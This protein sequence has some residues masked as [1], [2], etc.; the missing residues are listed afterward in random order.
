[1]AFCFHFQGQGF[2]EAYESYRQNSMKKIR[3]EQ[4]AMDALKNF[5]TTGNIQV[6]ENR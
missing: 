5:A 3:E 1:M 2:E 6:E 4:K